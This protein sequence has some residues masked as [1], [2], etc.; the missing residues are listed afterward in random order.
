MEVW[1][2]WRCDLMYDT[3]SDLDLHSLSNIASQ[4]ASV[5]MCRQYLRFASL[6]EWTLACAPSSGLRRNRRPL[7]VHIDLA[8]PSLLTTGLT[9]LT[10]AAE[11]SSYHAVC[12]RSVQCHL[13]RGFRPAAIA[14]TT[15]NLTALALYP[16]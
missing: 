2:H 10:N 8:R 6:R 5:S 7:R 4:I 12:Q 1:H 3:L 9:I 11:S 14:L 16:C 15:A 13:G